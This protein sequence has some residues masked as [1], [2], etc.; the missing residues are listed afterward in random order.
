MSEM[1]AKQYRKNFQKELKELLQKYGADIGIDDI[2]YGHS[3]D[4]QIVAD[5]DYHNSLGIIESI[6]FGSMISQ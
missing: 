6:N 3:S 4:L 5:F 2:G 1:T